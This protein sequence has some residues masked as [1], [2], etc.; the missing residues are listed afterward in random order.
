VRK[1]RQHRQQ[2]SPHSGSRP[3]SSSTA[4]LDRLS[5]LLSSILISNLR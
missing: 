4:H 3:L 5:D 2:W 1:H